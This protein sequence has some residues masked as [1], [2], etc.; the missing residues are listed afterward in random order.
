M[1]SLLRGNGAIEGISQ[2]IPKTHHPMVIT[3]HPAPMASLKSVLQPRCHRAWGHFN[4]VSCQV[5]KPTTALEEKHREK[6]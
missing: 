6:K 4:L 1:K 3:H 2:T 5:K